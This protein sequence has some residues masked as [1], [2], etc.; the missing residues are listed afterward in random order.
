MGMPDY[1]G[2]T[3]YY[4]QSGKNSENLL[5]SLFIMEKIKRYKVI[6]HLRI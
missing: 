4:K 6:T 1:K 2:M 5:E 3:V